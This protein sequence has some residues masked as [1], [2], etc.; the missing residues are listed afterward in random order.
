[1]LELLS[2]LPTNGGDGS[3]GFVLRGVSERDRLGGS[4]SGAGDI[5]GDGIDDLIVG[6][7]YGDPGERSNA[8]ESYVVFGRDTVQVGNF[9]AV[10]DLDDLLPDNGGDGSAGFV[11]NGIDVN[12]YS[13]SSVSRAGDINGDGIDDLIVGAPKAN[14]S[15]R[16]D[17]GQSYVVFGRNT[18]QVGNFLAVFPLLNLLPPRGGD[19]STGF[20]LSGINAYD[21]SGV[22]VSAAGDINVD[23]ITD[24]IIG[25]WQASPGGRIG[26]GQSYVVFGRNTTQAGNFPAIFPLASMLPQSGGDGSAGFVLNGIDGGDISNRGDYSGYFVSAAGDIDGDGIDDLL[27]DAPSAGVAGETYVFFGRDTTQTGNLPAVFPLAQLEQGAGGRAGFIVS[28]FS[29]ND[30]TGSSSS[31][32]GD[33]N[34]DGIDDLIIGAEDAHA[35]GRDSAGQSYV[36]FGREVAQ[37]GSFPKEFLLSDLLVA[38]GGEGTAGFV[39]NG[40]DAGDHSG[41][42]VSSA[43]DINGDGIDD[44]IIGARWADRGPSTNVGETYVVFGR[45][46]TGR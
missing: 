8:G 39:L 31:D 45:G 20:V 33:V 42:S 40:I 28:G 26:A 12:D 41:S 5:N 43:G 2:L 1:V 36:V 16:S 23:G 27:I 35:V 9:P 10:F 38:N 7:R 17:A 37:D 21:Q 34:G 30:D 32:A 3:E 19:G 13:G 44:L 11:I 22:A 29:G 46:T 14:P 24:L 18:A 6:A 4:V 15:G 25:A